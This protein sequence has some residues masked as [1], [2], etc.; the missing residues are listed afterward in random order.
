MKKFTYYFK[1]FESLLFITLLSIIFNFVSSMQAQV[2]IPFSGSNSIACGTNTGLCTHAGCGVTYSNSANGYTVINSAGTA[3][4][5]ISGSYS[6]ESG[7]DYIRIYS[8]S[9]TGGTLIQTYQ[10]SGS[11]NYT[12]SAGQTLTV[13][14]TSDGSV[15]YTG[16]NSTVLLSADHAVVA[17]A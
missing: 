8:G 11:I 15:T 5:N 16:L 12:G 3:V 4:I 9:G 1:K 6:T 17:D 14:F 2:L 13:Q 10:G 7:Y